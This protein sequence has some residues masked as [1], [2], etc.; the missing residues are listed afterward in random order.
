MSEQAGRAEGR[1]DDLS[2]LGLIGVNNWVRF[3]VDPFCPIIRQS[4]TGTY[5]DTYH[6]R[7]N[8]G[9]NV[10][11]TTFRTGLCPLE[12]MEYKVIGTAPNG[13]DFEMPVAADSKK[14][15]LEK[16]E[17][18]LPEHTIEGVLE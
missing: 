13:N 7:I 2:V 1:E 17:E 8:P 11:K 12:T 3:P 4:P 6:Q 9:V 10:P 5:L 18:Q 14:S 15:A 16:A